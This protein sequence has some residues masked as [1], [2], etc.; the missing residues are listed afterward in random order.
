[1]EDE[2]VSFETENYSKEAMEAGLKY[3]LK[4]LIL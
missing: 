1:M 3:A 4:N 2:F